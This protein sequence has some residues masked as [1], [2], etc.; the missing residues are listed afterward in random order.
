MGG[1]TATGGFSPGI[2]G[3]VAAAF[4][5]RPGHV[6][7]RAGC[8]LTIGTVSVGPQ[9]SRR[10]SPPGRAPPGD[11]R[12]APRFNGRPGD[13]FPRYPSAKDARSCHLVPSCTRSSTD[14]TSAV[15]GVPPRS[16]ASTLSRTASSCPWATV[17][18]GTTS[19]N[20]PPNGG[21]CGHRSAI[22]RVSC[23]NGPSGSGA[24]Y[25][26]PGNRPQLSNR[27]GKAGWAAST[28]SRA[29]WTAPSTQSSRRNGKST[30]TCAGTPSRAPGSSRS[31][32]AR[33]AG[34]ASGICTMSPVRPA[35]SSLVPSSVTAPV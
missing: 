10:P 27:T 18:C 1:R 15:M 26:T 20:R 33:T 34:S 25:S 23:R 5:Y 21:V 29:R 7:T 3:H 8:E 6:G 22:A 14:D 24:R 32:H 13:G 16:S 2:R 9:A 31:R 12:R 30:V 28:S 35:W 11:E 17:R 4:V 19:V